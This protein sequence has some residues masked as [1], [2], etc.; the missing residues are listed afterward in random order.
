MKHENT[1]H[2]YHRK[3]YIIENIWTLPFQ[4]LF[5]MYTILLLDNVR[6]D[7]RVMQISLTDDKHL[8]GSIFRT[9]K[10]L[11]QFLSI[12]ESLFLIVSVSFAR[13]EEIQL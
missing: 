5:K 3:I 11:M 9:Q 4:V 12:S 1:V 7:M 13:P 2:V 10:E 8:L 6:Q